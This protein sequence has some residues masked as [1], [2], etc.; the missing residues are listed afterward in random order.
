MVT[1]NSGGIDNAAITT[2]IILKQAQPNLVSLLDTFA[3]DAGRENDF[4]YY[5]QSATVFTLQNTVSPVVQV[6]S[7][8]GQINYSLS[9]NQS[10]TVFKPTTIPLAFFQSDGLSIPELSIASAVRKDLV[11]E[12][13]S[14]K[15]W[16]IGTRMLG[17]INTFITPAYYPTAFPLSS[18]S[19]TYKGFLNLVKAACQ[20]GWKREQLT[21]VLSVSAYNDLMG[22]L[23][24]LF[25]GNFSSVA[26][27]GAI[28]RLSGVTI[29]CC[30]VQP[31]GCSGYITTKDAF[32][33][34]VR[35][36]PEPPAGQSYGIWNVTTS[37]ETKL[38]M[39]L[40]YFVD[41]KQP[42]RNC[43]LDIAW[44]FAPINAYSL[45]RLTT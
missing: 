39:R 25:Q 4:A 26:E 45:I 17:Q 31:A 37:S 15:L 38:P 33:I 16:Q 22:D 28:A 2:G 8:G 19:L 27:D 44:G 32:G 43:E 34:V 11:E 21:C 7:G 42:D 18:A 23:P 29:K 30:D 13:V 40:R 41:P 3:I 6:I 24:S 5:G 20:I 14:T 36:L 10:D 9:V 12:A 1:Y 35:P